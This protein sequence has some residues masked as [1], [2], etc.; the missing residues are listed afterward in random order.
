MKK[1]FKL[2]SITAIGGMS[3]AAIISCVRPYS[4]SFDAKDLKS[5]SRAWNDQ[6]GNMVTFYANEIDSSDFSAKP[7]K[8]NIIDFIKMNINVAINDQ[9]SKVNLNKFLENDNTKFRF[10]KNKE[11]VMGYN[12]EGVEH[13]LDR[14]VIWF[15]ISDGKTSTSK[16]QLNIDAQKNKVSYFAIKNF[17]D[18][19]HGMDYITY[20]VNKNKNFVVNIDTSKIYL[21]DYIEKNGL[22]DDQTKEDLCRLV[23]EDIRTKIYSAIKN[24]LFN[25]G[26][27]PQIVN[28]PVNYFGSIKNTSSIE[29]YL[30]NYNGRGFEQGDE[31]SQAIS[32]VTKLTNG[33]K[34]SLKNATIH[35]W[36]YSLLLKD[37]INDHLNDDK[38]VDDD[39][40]TPNS[41]LLNFY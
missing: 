14:K 10:Y 24:E 22:G 1:L 25:N 37:D 30:T 26:T 5:I 13:L 7:S 19:N 33:S 17:D 2:L 38:F 27:T 15:D 16:M 20:L 11:D 4:Y 32:F 29:D 40:Q 34:P 18:N 3:T 12:I 31:Q 28:S 21:N 23:Y 9:N 6:L 36:H 41:I 8:N 39:S 35:K